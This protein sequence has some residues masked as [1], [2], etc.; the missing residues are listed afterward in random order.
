MTNAAYIIARLTAGTIE[1]GQLQKAQKLDELYEA[2]QVADELRDTIEANEE[3]LDD[4][5]VALDEATE[6]LKG[7]W[8]K[9]GAAVGND[10]GLADL[11]EEVGVIAADLE[12]A[13][14]K[15]VI[16][17]EDKGDIQD[18]V[19]DTNESMQ[20]STDFLDEVQL[21]LQRSTSSSLDS[22]S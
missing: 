2:E 5:T 1:D 16:A 17:E 3:L 22:D 13:G 8:G 20:S 10:Q 19:L 11:T 12:K 9:L 18:E 21:S 15:L 4:K 14:N 7:F 6:A